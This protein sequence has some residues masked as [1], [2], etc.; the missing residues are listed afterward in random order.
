[1]GLIV[2]KVVLGGNYDIRSSTY[3][4]RIAKSCPVTTALP[5]GSR[6][7]CKAGGIAWFVAPSCTQ[8]GQSWAGGSG[9]VCEWSSLSLAL[10]NNG[11]KPTDWFVPSISVLNNP[12]YVCRTNWDS[13]CSTNYWSSSQ[14]FFAP[15]AYRTNFTDG[16]S[17]IVNYNKGNSYC[18]RAFRCVTY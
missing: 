9:L 18:V 15:T 16:S 7:I 1:M 8:V 11:F 2:S 6:L 13:F 17:G 5:D 10:T 4:S 3:Y 12:G 14:G